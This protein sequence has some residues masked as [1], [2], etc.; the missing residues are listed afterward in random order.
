MRDVTIAFYS[1]KSRLFNSFL[2]IFLTAFGISIAIIITQ[3]GN[4]LS[5]RINSDGKKANIG[6]FKINEKIL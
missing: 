3:I 6:I 1:I 2:S 4:D 5:K